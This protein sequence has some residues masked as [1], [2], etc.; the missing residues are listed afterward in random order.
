VIYAAQGA[1]KWTLGK[2]SI[3]GG[4][5]IQLSDKAAAMPAVSPDNKFVAYLYPDSEDGFAPA[6]RLGII[7]IDGGEPS[8]AFSIQGSGTITTTLHWSTDGNLL[9]YTINANNVTNI[10][11]QPLDGSAPK[12]ITDFKDSLMLG[13]AYSHDGKQLAC[14]RGIL[15]R[16]AVLISEVK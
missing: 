9:L 4:K 6:N 8:K 14:S 15:L 11:G 2:V 12:Q 5:P 3:D 7:S 1:A 16:D 13:F 10:W